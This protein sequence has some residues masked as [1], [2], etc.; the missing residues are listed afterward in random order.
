MPAVDQPV[1]EV[2]KREVEGDVVFH[3]TIMGWF[4]NWHASSFIN[5]N[6]ETWIYKQRG[7]IKGHL[8]YIQ[9]DEGTKFLEGLTLVQQ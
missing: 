6:I 2:D 4:N 7:I 8:Q 1:C 9:W 5:P 3:L